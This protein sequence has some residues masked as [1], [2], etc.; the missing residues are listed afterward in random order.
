MLI[1]VINDDRENLSYDI[2]AFSERVQKHA[3]TLTIDLPDSVDHYDN[4]VDVGE[5]NKIEIFS[6]IDGTEYPVFR[7]DRYKELGYCAFRYDD[8][9]VDGYT[10]SGSVMEF[11]A[12]RES[13]V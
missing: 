5:I 12:T 13:K 6:E 2:L 1:L 8:R 9:P 7:T 10:H 11:T 3:Y 4:I